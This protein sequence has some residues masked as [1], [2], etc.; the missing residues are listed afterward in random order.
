MS[1]LPARCKLGVTSAGRRRSPR[2]AD[3][4]N[5]QARRSVVRGLLARGLPMLPCRAAR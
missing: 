1:A 5:L 4:L 3:T 2:W